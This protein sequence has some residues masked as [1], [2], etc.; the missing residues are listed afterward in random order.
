MHQVLLSFLNK[1]LVV[2]FDD[3]LVYNINE[4]DHLQHL[5][6]VFEALEK[7]ELYINSKKCTFWGSSIPRVY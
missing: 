3:I 6:L 2:Y 1:F 5:K 4:E 7:N